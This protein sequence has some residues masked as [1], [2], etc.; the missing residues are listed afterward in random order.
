MQPEKVAQSSKHSS[1][2]IELPPGRAADDASWCPGPASNTL[3][4]NRR[5]WR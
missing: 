1:I 4:K 2:F 5:F 3:G